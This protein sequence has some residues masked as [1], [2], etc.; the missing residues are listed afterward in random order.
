M[1]DL[2]AGIG[3]FTLAG[4]R[5]GWETVAFVEWEKY[6]QKVLAK[7]FPGVP[8]H[9]DIREVNF[10]DYEGVDII[11]GGFPCQPF[12]AAGKRKGAEDD[13]YLWPEMLRAI[14]EAKPTWVVGENVAGLLTMDGGSVFEEICASLEDEGYTVE[15]FVLPAISKG[16][17]HRRDRV[18]IV[19]H[20]R[21]AISGTAP[22][23]IQGPEGAERIRQQHGL[24]E[25]GQSNQ[26]GDSS[27]ASEE[28]LQGLEQRGAF[29]EGAG[30]SRPTA[31]C[32]TDAA[33]T[34]YNA[35]SSTS[36]GYRRIE[37][38]KGWEEKQESAKQFKGSYNFTEL[39]QYPWYEV[40]TRLCRMDDGLPSWVDR[41]R[42]N[43]LK[44]LGNAI[45]PQVAYEIFRA[46]NQV[47][48]SSKPQKR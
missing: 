25:L 6:P 24:A 7:N 18:W 47:N 31:E 34:G 42:T 36:K 46:I 43:R 3:G 27:N 40:A 16:A 1:L 35:A 38:H 4:H 12:S 11:C 17:P 2:F 21:H 8:I 41:H 37:Q 23:D 5:A 32:D 44:A 26:V 20:S 29:G 33:D 19:A 28:G 48:N 30:A 45:V 15:S 10:K 13:R 22:G 14:R 9:G 39:W